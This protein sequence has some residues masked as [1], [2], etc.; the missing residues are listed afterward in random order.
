MR[1]ARPPAF[2]RTTCSRIA[3]YARWSGARHFAGGHP[4]EAHPFVVAL[5]SATN[6][7][8]L[9]RE[10][11]TMVGHFLGEDEIIRGVR[12]KPGPAV[13]EISSG[14]YE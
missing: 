1:T 3:S 12:E 6:L 11:G 13:R 8:A 7:D 5:R 9:M 14:V 2:E 4:G 10:Q